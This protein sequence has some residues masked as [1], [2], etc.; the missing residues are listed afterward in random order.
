MENAWNTNSETGWEQCPKLFLNSTR[1]ISDHIKIPKY[2][3][4]WSSKILGN[5]LWN[6]D[7]PKS[8]MVWEILWKDFLKISFWKSAFNLKIFL[9]FWR[10]LVAKRYWAKIFERF[11]TIANRVELGKEC[12]YLIDFIYSHDFTPCTNWKRNGFHIDFIFLK[13]KLSFSWSKR[14]YTVI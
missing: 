1:Q 6:S 4:L 13:L 14:L 5:I 11:H 9:S 3:G 2:C 8:N 7:K 10:I 12:F